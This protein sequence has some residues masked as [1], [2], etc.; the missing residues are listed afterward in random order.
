MSRT[1]LLMAHPG[2]ELLLHHW[3]E[4]HRPTVFALSDGSGS[5][6]I[7][8]VERSKH[9]IEAGGAKVGSIFGLLPDAAWYEAIATQDVA[10][11]I[12]VVKSI[13]MAGD[14]M[15]QVI[16]SDS[17]EYFNPLHDLCC[18]L[19]H[20]VACQASARGSGFVQHLDYPIEASS[21]RRP[22]MLL[23]LDQA[24][25]ARKHAVIANYEGLRREVERR[26][27][28]MNLEDLGRETLHPARCLEM[29]PETLPFEPLYE[30]Y[31]RMRVNS[32]VYHDVITY[33]GHVRPIAMR[34]IDQ[35]S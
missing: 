28:G 1:V 25:L 27:A 16:V 21:D 23:Q 26:G 9:V 19:A 12:Q 30:K 7:P 22:E 35:A 4:R 10:P 3:M 31:G 24:A 14:E 13:A 18:V 20:I 6:G 34:L 8:R 11:F 33:S 17:I 32:G 15:P 5:L 2:H 29:W